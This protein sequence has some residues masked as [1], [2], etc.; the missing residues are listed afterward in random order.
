MA[1]I[2]LVVSVIMSGSGVFASQSPDNE[3]K[4]VNTKKSDNDDSDSIDILETLSS[5]SI[6]LP[7]EGTIAVIIF[8]GSITSVVYVLFI[9]QK[10]KA[11]VSLPMGPKK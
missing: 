8:V 9:N 7:I 6:F 1:I 10:K 3:G 11:N 4:N 2:I 5:D